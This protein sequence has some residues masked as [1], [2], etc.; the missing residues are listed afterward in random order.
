MKLEQ[1]KPKLDDCHHLS[2]NRQFTGIKGCAKSQLI[3][4]LIY[5]HSSAAK[6]SP[7]CSFL[8]GGCKSLVI[9]ILQAE[10]F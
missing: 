1:I 10:T 4:Y 6:R 5:F 8:F 2:T 3:L 7:S 9:Q